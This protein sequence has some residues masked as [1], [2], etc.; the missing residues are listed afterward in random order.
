MNHHNIPINLLINPYY[1]PYANL[2]ANLEDYQRSIEKATGL[3][4][5][6]YA[7]AVKDEMGF[8]DYQH[9]NKFGSK[10]Y[11]DQLYKDGLLDKP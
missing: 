3:K 11:L 4:V 6:N 9:V 1:P 7:Y 8:G 5:H 2:I 10:Q